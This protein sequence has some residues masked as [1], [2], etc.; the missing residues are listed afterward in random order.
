[1]EIKIIWANNQHW[2]VQRIAS[3]QFHDYNERYLYLGVYGEG[4][5]VNANLV[6]QA[7]YPGNQ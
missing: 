6:Y 4:Q 5:I 7:L 2:G 1:M 3:G